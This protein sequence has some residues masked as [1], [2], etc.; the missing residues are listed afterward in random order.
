MLNK[1]KVKVKVRSKFFISIWKVDT[2]QKDL[3]QLS[4]EDDN[5]MAGPTHAKVCIALFFSFVY[6]LSFLQH[7]S[8]S[9]IRSSSVAFNIY[10]P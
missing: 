3:K 9:N 5:L 2:F 1:I 10:C 7:T 4:D 8:A 6:N